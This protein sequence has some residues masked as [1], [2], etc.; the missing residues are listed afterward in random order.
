[1]QYKKNLKLRAVNWGKNATPG[2]LK[3]ASRG[4]REDQTTYGNALISRN[5]HKLAEALQEITT[6]KKGRMPAPAV[7]L[8]SIGK[9]QVIAMLTLKGVIGSLTS[10]RTLSSVAIEVGGMLEEEALNAAAEEDAKKHIKNALAKKSSIR[11]KRKALEY[12][13]EAWDVEFDHWRTDEKLKVGLL[14]IDTLIATIGLVRVERLEGK[15]KRKGADTLV[16]ESNVVDWINK[17]RDEFA[18]LSPVYLPMVVKP[19]EWNRDTI[20]SGCYL[21]DQ[22]APVPFVKRRKKLQMQRLKEQNPEHVFRAVNKVQETAWRIR[23][24]VL[25]LIKHMLAC[26]DTCGLSNDKFVSLVNL[27]VGE[28]ATWQEKMVAQKENRERANLRLNVASNIAIAEQFKDF[29]AFYVP[30]HLDTRG[31]VYPITTLNPQGADYIKG[32]LEFSEGKLL[33]ADGIY[34]LKV[35]AANLWGVDKVPFDDRVQ[36]VNENMSKIVAS[37]DDPFNNRFW[38][39]AD[40]PFQAFAVAHELMGVLFH[41]EECV[42]RMPIAL[43]GSCSGLQHLGAAF[44]CSITAKAVNLLPGDKPNDIYQDVADKLTEMLKAETGE[45]KQYADQWLEFCGGHV[46]RKVTKRSVM[47]FP[48]G[49]KASGFKDQL[50]TDTLDP[51]LKAGNKFPFE[52]DGYAAAAYLAPVLERAVSSTVLKAAEAMRW[53]Q[54]TAS[55]IA[56]GGKAI[57]WTTPLGFPVV[58]EY[59]KLKSREVDSVINGKRYRSGFTEEQDTIDTLKMRNGSAPNV[60]HSLDSTHLLLT[61]LHGNDEGLNAFALIHDSFG[62]HAADTTRF[63]SIIREAFVEQYS[64]PVFD[65]LKRQFVSQVTPERSKKIPELPKSGD[66]QIESIL[67][68]FY[69]F[70]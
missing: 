62:V 69:A 36:W 52:G 56:S 61:V 14:C 13:A 7:L 35:H 23:K 12:V 59:R 42:S 34:W 64:S 49:S 18:L 19:R 32:L 29:E 25:D 28:D 16:A 48:Y 63:F 5:I 37:A 60:V 47:T 55:L 15:G 17:H 44:K 67:E 66:Y 31:R 50:K 3:K 45:R 58:Q 57:E 30:H 21:T 8:Q 11:G 43:D 2:E 22:Q 46:S 68:S 9:P 20:N 6:P 4:K 70:A 1:M 26:G 65:L 51:A 38:T 53:I 41:G 54:E 24:P 40:K 10:N 39:E 33:G 27:C